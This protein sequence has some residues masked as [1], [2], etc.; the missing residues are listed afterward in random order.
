LEA[1]KACFQGEFVRKSDFSAFLHKLK[2]GIEFQS[3]DINGRISLAECF[4]LVGPAPKP[5]GS[6]LVQAMEGTLSGGLQQISAKRGFK[7]TNLT[8]APEM[9]VQVM[10]RVF[11]W[12]PPPEP[13][14]D[15]CS[16]YEAEERLAC[17]PADIAALL[18]AGALRRTHK[19]S[20][21]LDRSSVI[22]VSHS[23]ISTR[24]I[25]ARLGIETQQIGPWARKWLLSKPD[26]ITLW[27]RGEIE[28][29]LPIM[30]TPFQNRSTIPFQG[31]SVLQ[32][33]R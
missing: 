10:T 28:P 9:A 30:K 15:H 32:K 14:R 8:L 16:Q 1:V 4:A 13:N 20:A 3:S 26:G 22:E 31:Q 18:K 29:F 2:M 27:D 6:L 23:F 19:A 7:P 12:S 11:T 17:N 33:L 5:W 21:K 25:A 24:E